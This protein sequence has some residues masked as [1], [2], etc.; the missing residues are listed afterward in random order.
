MVG[1]Q[2]GYSILLPA[3]GSCHT[4]SLNRRIFRLD[5]EEVMADY[6]SL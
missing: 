4:V 6:D 2:A 5:A 3:T 1:L